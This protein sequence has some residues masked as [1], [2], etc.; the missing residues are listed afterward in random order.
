MSRRV[1]W[2]IGIAVVVGLFVI[3]PRTVFRPKPI[4]VE[5]GQAAMGPVEDVVTNSE[6]GTVRSRAE[7]DLGAE[8][9]GRVA[10]ILHREGTSAKRG[11]VIVQLDSTTA[12]TQLEA[13][14]RDRD[15]MRAASVAAEAAGRLTRQQWDRQQE[16]R[17]QGLVSQATI[18]EAKSALDRADAERQA[19]AARYEGA[20]S[21][22]RLARD[23][24]AHLQ[25]RAPFDGVV[26]RRF[27]EV[28]EAV[29]PG[30]TVAQLVS[31]DRLYASAPIDERDAGNLRAG[32]PA[33][34]LIDTYPGEVWKGTVARVAPVVDEVKAQNRTLEV[35]VDL[36]VEKG[37]PVLRPGMTADVEVVLDRRDRVLRVPSAAVIEGRR[38]LVV[39]RGQAAEREVTLGL[40]NW[41]WTEVREGLEEG[42]R[43]ITSLDRQGLKSGVAVR[44]KSSEGGS[45]EGTATAATP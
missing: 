28:G 18:D 40:R 19:A 14:R 16:L 23:E 9:A 39:D 13:A 31:L 6:A 10:A 24:L 36:P 27:V 12:A 33:R 15:A 32:L 42:D 37:R 25:V 45:A 20:E 30:Q 29:V 7:S 5:V 1:K 11:E 2:G 35:E 38:V 34:V 26:T 17:A 8:R 4:E 21:A 41:E 44:V 22:V 43:V 3:L